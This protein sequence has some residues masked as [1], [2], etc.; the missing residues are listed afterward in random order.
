VKHIK[1]RWCLYYSTGFIYDH[2]LRS[3]KYFYNTGHRSHHVNKPFIQSY[4]KIWTEIRPIFQRVD[5]S[6]CNQKRPKY[7]QQTSIWMP[8][9]STLTHFWNLK[10]PATNCLET[11]YIGEKLINLLRQKVAQN[12]AISLD[13]FI[14]SKNHNAPPK[15][16]QLAK[17][18][19]I[20]SP[21]L[22]YCDISAI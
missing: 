1:W 21:C 15:V 10:I 22:Y 17:N 19:P 13:Y 5:Q 7:L 2:H 9:T 3:S 14:F 4:K 8:K 20:W 6:V 16:A 12:A 11:T 18:C